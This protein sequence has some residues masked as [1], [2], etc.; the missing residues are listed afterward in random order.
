MK[1]CVVDFEYG[2]DVD[3]D[4]N[5]L[6]EEVDAATL[7]AW[8]TAWGRKEATLPEREMKSDIVAML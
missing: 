3:V 8:R 1:R 2:V 4:A 7:V 5:A 6:E